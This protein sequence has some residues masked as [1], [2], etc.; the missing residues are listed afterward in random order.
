MI[1]GMSKLPRALLSPP[2]LH[3]LCVK[4]SDLHVCKMHTQVQYRRRAMRNM[5]KLLFRAALQS[6]HGKIQC[7]PA[8]SNFIATPASCFGHAVQILRRALTLQCNEMQ[9]QRNGKHEQATVSSWL[10]KLSCNS[11]LRAGRGS[12]PMSLTLTRGLNAD[13]M[14]QHMLCFALR[15]GSAVRQA[16]V[17]L[18]LLKLSCNRSLRAG[19]GSVPMSLTF[20]RGLSADDMQQHTLCFALRQGSAVR[21]ATVS[22]RLRKLSCNR[23]LRAGCG[24]VPMYLT[25]TRGLSA[26]Y[27]QQ[28]TLCFSLRQGCVVL[29]RALGSTVRCNAAAGQ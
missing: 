7:F 23:S 11:S 3:V 17:S 27:I 14:Q 15:Q 24:R 21:Q 2:H 20:T 18:R 29:V 6:I 25:L 10:L 16:T 9:T 28:R 13:D 19:R 4:V 5:V 12:V 26:D 1:S 22:L 8:L